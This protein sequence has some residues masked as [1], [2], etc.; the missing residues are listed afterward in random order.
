VAPE[1][2]MKEIKKIHQFLVFSV[3]SLC[4]VASEYLDVVSVDG[5]R[6]V[7]RKRDYF[8]KL[9]ETSRFTLPCEGTYFQV[10]SYAAISTENDVAFCKG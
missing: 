7:S 3:N 2:L 1:Y 5:I 9:L 6:Y 4:Q 10:A 8:R